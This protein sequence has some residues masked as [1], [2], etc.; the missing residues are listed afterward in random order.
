MRPT[1]S[2]SGWPSGHWTRR[3][4]CGSCWPATR[5]A[6]A[7]TWR[8]SSTTGRSC[9]TPARS[10]PGWTRSPR[11]ED[12]LTARG[13]VQLSGQVLEPG[14]QVAD[15]LHDG[16]LA[17]VGVA[18]GEL[19]AGVR[20][21]L[22]EAVVGG[23]V[24][25]LLIGG[26]LALGCRAHR[27]AGRPLR[28]L[29]RLADLTLEVGHPGFE[30]AVGDRLRGCFRRRRSGLPLTLDLRVG[31]LHRLEALRGLGRAAVVVGVGR[32]DQLPVRRADLRVG[33]GPAHAEE[34][35]RVAHRWL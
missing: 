8:R 11:A 24:A 30:A 32:L 9:A 20:E 25:E 13:P 7:S 21:D 26:S 6:P 3:S 27:L 2:S 16:V 10:S 19:R 14:D 4:R 15:P 12:S 18:L 33:G 17:G 35:V 34:L 31:V 23:E 5:P 22:R 29:P 28:A 1:G